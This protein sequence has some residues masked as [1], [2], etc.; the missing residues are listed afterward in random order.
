[1]FSWLKQKA[2]EVEPPPVPA[3]KTGLY[4][5]NKSWWRY[6]YA[7]FILEI[8]FK[9]D[10]SVVLKSIFGLQ[11]WEKQES[12][13][14]YMNVTYTSTSYT[15]T[16]VIDKVEENVRIWKYHVDQYLATM[17]RFDNTLENLIGK[18]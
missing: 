7:N 15:H 11:N 5:D 18:V 1:M 12:L 16:T 6:Y 8:D 13:S 10:Y 9:Y 3:Q 14:S 17:Q 2:T 4:R